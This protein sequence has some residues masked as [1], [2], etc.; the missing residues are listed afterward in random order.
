M[1][2]RNSLLGRLPGKRTTAILRENLAQLH[3]I[4]EKGET[5]STEKADYITDYLGFSPQIEFVL[6]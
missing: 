2:Q 3:R 4:S 5:N 6:E 1:T